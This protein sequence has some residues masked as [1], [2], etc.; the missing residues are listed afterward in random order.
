MPI[1][2]EKIKEKNN[3]DPLVTLSSIRGMIL[4][5]QTNCTGELF[6]KEEIDKMRIRKIKNNFGETIIKVNGEI[7]LNLQIKNGDRFLFISYDQSVLTHGLHKYPAKFFPEL[8]RWLIQRY[9]QKNDWVLDPFAGSGTTNLECLLARRNSV[10]IDIDPF[11]RFLTKVKITPLKKDA[12]QK[13]YT[14]L[15]KKIL[16]YDKDSLTKGDFPNFPYRDNWFNSYVI[17]ELAYIKK[18]ILNLS[19][20]MYGDFSKKDVRDITDFFLVSFSS[21]IRSVSN[22]DDNCTRT[23]IRKKLNKQVKKGDALNKFIKAID[24]DVPKMLLFST[25]CPANIKVEIPEDSDARNIKYPDNFFRLAVTSPPYVNAVDYPRTHQLE[26]YWLGIENG[27]L[28]PL[29]KLHVGTESV[30]HNEYKHLHK[31]GFK[32]I[33]NIL[34]ALYVK[35]PRRSYILYKFLIDMQNNLLEVKRVLKPGGIYAVVI[36]NNKMRGI[37][38]ESWKYLMGIGEE[39]GFKIETYFASEIIKHFIKVPREERIENDWVIIFKKPY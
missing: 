29:K 33:D 30:L 38:I 22:A 20:I 17:D 13:T 7:P 31:T 11:A 15:K 36:G 37:L 27:S 6:S 9:S 25:V 23:V 34:K 28:A 10:A 39:L 2:Q 21:I 12:L 24:E 8:P 3:N 16:Q 32:Y 26:I 1:T 19:R 18:N 5:H 4:S 14:Y 35:D